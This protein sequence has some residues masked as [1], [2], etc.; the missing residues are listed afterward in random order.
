[1]VLKLEV[2]LFCFAVDVTSEQESC[3]NN[4]GEVSE[5]IIERAMS[6]I[7]QHITIAKKYFSKE[8]M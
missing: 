7:Q 2:F 6:N 8:W 5:Q 4:S 1:M 3:D